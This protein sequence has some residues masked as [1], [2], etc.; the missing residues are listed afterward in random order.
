MDEESD[1]DL[2]NNYNQRR[3]ED[4]V[5]CDDASSTKRKRGRPPKGVKKS[6]KEKKEKKQKV[7]E[8][9]PVEF[10]DQEIPS[11]SPKKAVVESVIVNPRTSVGTV[12]SAPVPSAVSVERSKYDLSEV[13][14][15]K[16]MITLIAQNS[17]DYLVAQPVI[18][19][20]PKACAELIGLKDWDKLLWLLTMNKRKQFLS[21]VDAFISHLLET[22]KIDIRSLEA[23][24]ILYIKTA[25]KNIVD[26]FEKQTKS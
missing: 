4:D 12:V 2:N 1:P 10:E 19:S 16:D 9:E 23:A 21:D 18:K 11:G 26:L 3:G 7:K 15:Y 8:N 5:A 6:K 24:A 22:Y 14:S 25:F 13:K 17:I 20:N